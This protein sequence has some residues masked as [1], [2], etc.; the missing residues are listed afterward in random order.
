MPHPS[1]VNAA[2]AVTP[3]RLNRFRREL[4]ARM[5]ERAARVYLQ[6]SGQ[7][8][9]AGFAMKKQGSPFSLT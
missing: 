7:D 8:F 2:A 9:S 5:S 4:A 1:P 3:D 6:P